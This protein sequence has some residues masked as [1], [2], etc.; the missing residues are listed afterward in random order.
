MASQNPNRDTQFML[1][2]LID[3]KPPS[4][5]PELEGRVAEEQQRSQNRQVLK[6]N[7]PKRK[8]SLSPQKDGAI[9]IPG[10]RSHDFN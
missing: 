2:D 9:K 8:R 4:S 1:K 7:V 10:V 5:L 3:L 6:K